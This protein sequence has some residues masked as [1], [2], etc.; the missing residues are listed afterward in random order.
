MAA[1][2]LRRRRLAFGFTGAGALL[3]AGAL[4]VWFAVVEPVN[5]HWAATGPAAVPEGFQALRARWEY[6]HLAHASLVF[7]AFVALLVSVLAEAPGGRAAGRQRSGRWRRA[8]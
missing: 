5:P 1:Y 3:L 8:A 7:A 6:G 4:V 2:L